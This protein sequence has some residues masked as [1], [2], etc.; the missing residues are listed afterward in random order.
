AEITKVF[1]EEGLGFLIESREAAKAEAAAD[2]SEGD[3]S[4]GD[5]SE[6]DA[7]EGAA[8][9]TAE[10]ETAIAKRE[11]SD[12]ELG[13][14][15]RRTLERLGPTFVKFGQMLATRVDLFSEELIDELA[16]L[17]SEAQPF[18]TPEARAIMEAEL[19]RPLDEVFEE[20]SEA[21]VAAASIAQVYKARLRD[22]G[23]QDHGWVAI[24]VQR[25]KLEDSLLRDLDVLVD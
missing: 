23:D 13:R 2:A 21:P 8:S 4:E 19:G 22:R 6:G 18:P 17:H 14:R 3:A 25:P 20:L 16:K 5:A 24:K 11:T 7:S 1:I 15:L 10:T 9:E 12:A